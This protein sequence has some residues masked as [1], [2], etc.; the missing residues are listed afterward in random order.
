MKARKIHNP[1]LI[2]TVLFPLAAAMVFSFFLYSGKSMMWK[3]DGVYQHYNAFLYLGSWMRTILQTLITEHRFIIPMF[4]W[5]LG[6]GSD[7]ITTLSYYTF[8]DPFALISVITP[9][10]YGEIG[11]VF[12]ILLRFYTAGLAFIAYARHM[13]CAAWSTVCAALMYVFCSYSLT[14]GVR[15]PY[16]IAPM[17]YLPLIL[18]GCEKMIQNKSPLPFTLSVF[19]AAF[20]NFYFFYMI[21]IITITYVALRLLCDK[22]YRRVKTLGRYFVRFFG[23]AVLGCAMAAVLLLPNIINFIGN[24]RVSHSYT[25]DFL[26]TGAQYQAL[27]GSAVGTHAAIPYALIGMAPLA[28]LG[29]SGILTEKTQPR[30]MKLMLLVEILFLVFPVA[31]YTMNGFGYVSNRWVFAWSFL[32]SYMFAK[33][34]PLLFAMNFRRKIALCAGCILYVLGCILLPGSHTKSTLAGCALFC[35]SLIFVLCARHIPDLSF[36]RLHVSNMQIRQAVTLLLSVVC[37]FTLA[38]YKYPSNE[39]NYLSEFQHLGTGNDLLI[40]NRAAAW[41]LI[42][43][44]EFYRIDND[45]AQNTQAN[46]LISLHQSTTGIYWSIINAKLVDFIRQTNAYYRM[47]YYLQ[48]LSSRAYLLPL[49]SAKYFVT[50]S[51]DA[52]QA[53]IPF[54]YFLVGEKEGFSD[55]YRLYQTRNVLPF[56]CTYDRILPRSDFDKLSLLQRQQA[57]LEGAVLDTEIAAALPLP[58]AEPDYNDKS[59]P[60]E[61]ICDGNVTYSGDTFVAAENNASVTL[62]FPAAD[63]GELYLQILGL[64]YRTDAGQNNLFGLNQDNNAAKT[65]L[66][67]ACGDVSVKYSHYAARSSYTVGRTDYLMHLG[68]SDKAR[69]SITLTFAKKGSYHIDRLSVLLQPMGRLC[70]QIRKL[71][72]NILTDVKMDTNRITGNISLDASKLLFLSLPY[73]KGWHVFVDGKEE[74]LLSA[75]LMYSGVM[76]TAGRHTIKLTYQTPYLLTGALISLFGFILFFTLFCCRKKLYQGQHRQPVTMR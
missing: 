25:F 67:A 53:L 65:A 33:G 42:N 3:R 27:W 32:T 10:K 31:G 35:I 52:E 72:H 68:Y 70:G 17:V 73:S 50:G 29:V 7:V 15:H 9:T 41:E 61:I 47:T 58:K 11:F 1:Y 8:G 54:G 22:R 26:Y 76:L 2:Y 23:Y 59:I 24:P 39:G 12:S 19:L 21:V 4:E 56:G 16:F 45:V 55:T 75:N 34:F 43:D 62:Q 64:D 40:D 51:S 44:T 37:V 6:Y 36:D 38:Y 20:S 57:M 49:A 66:S 74:T 60:Y 48:G 63:A 14:T 71:R 69:T 28:Y 46:H 30:W 13:K 5:G 18:I